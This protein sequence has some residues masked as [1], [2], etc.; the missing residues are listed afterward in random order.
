MFLFS[1][2]LAGLKRTSPI[3]QSHTRPPKM[4]YADVPEQMINPDLLLPGR[5]G[6]PV[7]PLMSPEINS[8]TA[9][10]RHHVVRSRHDDGMLSSSSSSAC[11]NSKKHKK[12]KKHK[13][14]HHK[15]KTN[16]K[17]KKRHKDYHDDHDYE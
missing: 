1:F 13:K 17:S 16:K 14:H 9:D 4:M 12:K 7:G 2:Y 8:L 11:S 10:E 6:I 3:V 5:S 15:H